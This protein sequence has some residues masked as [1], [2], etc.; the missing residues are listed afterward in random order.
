MPKTSSIRSAVL[1]GLRLV[2]DADRHKPMASKTYLARGQ[3]VLLLFLVSN[4]LCQ[5]N[6]LNVYRID[7]RHVFRIG[8]TVAV[9]DQPQVSF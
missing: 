1:V 3:Y 5:T 6:Y 9:D 2:T 8:R 4:D 7:L